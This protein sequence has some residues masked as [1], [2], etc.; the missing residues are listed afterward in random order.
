MNRLIS[1]LFSVA[2]ALLV[3]YSTVFVVDQK[4]HAIVFAFGEVKSVISEPGLHFKLPAPFQNVMFLDKRIL[5]IESPDADRFITAEK[6]NILVDTFVKWHIIDP[7]LYYVSFS[8]VE[9]RAGDRLSQ[10]V[11]A[12]LNE[13]ITKRSVRDVISGERDKVMQAIRAKVTEE[14]KQIGVEIIDVRLKRVEY[15][16]ENIG[17]VFDRMK[18]ERSRVANELRSTGFAESEKIQADADRQRVVILAEAYKEAESIR[19]AGDAEAAKI[20]SQAFS[21]NAEF[22]KFY[23]S[24]EAYRASFKNKSDVMVVDPN[25]EFFKYFKAPGAANAAPSKK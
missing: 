5:T 21:Q 20:Y 9:S 2:I 25:S 13:E 11:K 24:L 7:K 19:G 18:S 6:K 1:F 10:I 3:L 16:N 17:S 15:V 8:G 4:S 14:A 12:A 23:R 22:Y